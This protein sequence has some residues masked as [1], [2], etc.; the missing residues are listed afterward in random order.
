MFELAP[1]TL[2]QC[3]DEINLLRYGEAPLAGHGGPTSA[4]ATAL[5]PRAR[6][7]GTDVED[8]VVYSRCGRQDG[9]TPQRLP[10]PPHG[11]ART[12]RPESRG[13]PNTLPPPASLPPRPADVRLGIWNIQVWLVAWVRRQG[14]GALAGAWGRPHT[15][16]GRHTHTHTHIVTCVLCAVCCVRRVSGAFPVYPA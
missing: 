10:A 16:R 8:A 1:G 14:S 13:L 15:R 6:R 3:S 11:W 2:G 12:V 9:N 4:A 7:R 5:T